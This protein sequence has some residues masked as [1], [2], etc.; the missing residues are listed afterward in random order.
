MS[1]AWI[2]GYDIPDPRRLG[3]VHRAMVNRPSPSEDTSFLCTGN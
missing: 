3:R 2:I 1:R